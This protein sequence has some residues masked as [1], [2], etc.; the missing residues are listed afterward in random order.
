VNEH[1]VLDHLGNLGVA[2]LAVLLFT[3]V[4][5]LFLKHLNRD[6][7]LVDKLPQIRLVYILIFSLVAHSIEITLL[8]MAYKASI[9]EPSSSLTQRSPPRTL[10]TSRQKV[11]C[12]CWRAWKL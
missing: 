7:R 6:A 9:T 5:Y 2:L 4:Y 3:S 10:A 1:T 12:G 8:A 11:L